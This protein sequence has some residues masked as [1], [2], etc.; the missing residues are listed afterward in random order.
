VK[1][2]EIWAAETWNQPLPG[3][4]VHAFHFSINNLKIHR[5]PKKRV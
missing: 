2:L 5:D 1:D 3:Y 4:G